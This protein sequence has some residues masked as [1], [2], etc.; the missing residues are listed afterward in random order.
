MK[1]KLPLIIVGVVVVVALVIG[2]WWFLGRGQQISLPTAPSKVGEQVPAEEGGSFV[3]K[4]KDALTLGQS[5]KCTW[6]KDE[7]NS[8]TSY[9]KDTNIRTEITQEGEK[10][11]VIVKDNCTYSWQE[12]ESD[13][14][15]ACFEP[16]EMEVEEE[17][18]GVAAPEETT[19]ETP[20]YEYNCE[21]AIVPE[22]MFNL[23]AGINFLSM[24]EMMGG[25]GE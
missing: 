8:A 20:D 2:G 10:A 21:P 12:G 1:K 4:L 23:P 13:G 16:E 19:M 5:M 15:K 25:M 7:N 11:Y 14:F 9:I 24:E 17:E 22:S 18:R 3:G 6:K